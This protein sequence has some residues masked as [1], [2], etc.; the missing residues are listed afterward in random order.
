[1][2]NSVKVD[3]SWKTVANNYVK[4]AGVWKKANAG[5]VKDAGVWRTFFYDPGQQL[6]TANTS[7]PVPPG[8]STVCIV[9]VGAGGTGSGPGGGGGA[10]S[11]SNNVAVT[12]GETLTIVVGTNVS[13]NGGDSYV[14][15]SATTLVKA[16]GGLGGTL[17]SGG[18][19]S[20][21]IGDVKY[22]GGNGGVGDAEAGGGAAGYAGNGGAADGGD[23]S[24]GGGGAGR[25]DHNNGAGGGG[26]GGLS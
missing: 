11:Y 2:T 12:A 23:G 21:G 8:V 1:M 14:N 3:G 18:A 5:F 19:A 13:A 25:F 4:V 15:R 10:L 6:F 9:C 20:G 7:W 17:R 26:G 22:S 24:G 16:K